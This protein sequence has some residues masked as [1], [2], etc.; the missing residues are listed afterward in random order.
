[1]KIIYS[2]DKRQEF[3]S[4]LVWKKTTLSD[5]LLAAAARAIELG[6]FNVWQI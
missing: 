4:N 6:Y 5:W 1:M 3:F 2:K